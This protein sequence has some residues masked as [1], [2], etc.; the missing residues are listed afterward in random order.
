METK[1]AMIRARVDPTLKIE[2]KGILS[3]LGLSTS[4]PINLFYHQVKLTKG[5]P[6]AVRIPNKTTVR[7]FKETDAGR[8]MVC[9]Q[10]AQDLFGKLG[11]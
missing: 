5:L 8:G 9:C 2:V 11:I 6:F 4:E 3:Q 1:S 7:T 10:N